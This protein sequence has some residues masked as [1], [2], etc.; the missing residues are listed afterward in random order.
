AVRVPLSAPEP[1][2]R[3]IVVG[4]RA[5]TDPAASATQLAELFDV[6]RF[7][8]GLAFVPPGTPTNNTETDRSA[9]TRRPD[10]AALFDAERV[11]DPSPTTYAATTAA[12]LGVPA[13]AVGGLP[14]ANATTAVADGSL[15]EA[16]WPATIGYF[17]ENL[18]QP[19]VDDRTVEAVRR[20]F[21]GAVRGL[22]PLPAVRI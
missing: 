6:Q 1:F 17:V 2:D 7:T 20:L 18:I 8:S 15:Y 16:P 22:G 11:R 5:G 4:V 19:A 9:W 10:A 3:V 21:V 14:D 13:D 12:A